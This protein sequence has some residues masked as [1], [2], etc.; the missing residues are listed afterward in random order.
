[1]LTLSSESLIEAL[2]VVDKKRER[3]DEASSGSMS[4]LLQI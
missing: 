3:K 4:A 1:M 2:R